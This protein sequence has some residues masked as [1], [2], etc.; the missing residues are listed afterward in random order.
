MYRGNGRRVGAFPISND[1]LYVW[2]TYQIQ[3][4]CTDL[5][6]KT[7]VTPFINH[8]E[9]FGGHWKEIA[10]ELKKVNFLFC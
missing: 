3:R 1:R 5:Q 4:D 6:R 9:G 8:F 2:G 7:Y 10:Q